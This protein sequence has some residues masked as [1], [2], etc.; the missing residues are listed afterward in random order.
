M[1][2]KIGTRQSKLALIQTEMVVLKIKSKIPDAVCEIVPIVTTGD[3]ITNKNLYDIG[4]KA[5][6][7]KEI[8]ESL[9]AGNIDLAVHSLKDVPGII[10]ENLEIAAV[11][12]REDPRDCFVSFKY[13]SIDSIPLNGVIG[14]SS[15]RRKVI[16]RQKRPDLKLVQFR[17][18]INTRMQKLRDAEVDG[19]ILACAGLKRG[20]LFDP[21]C[22][23]P[24]EF[25]EMLPAAGQ[26]IIGLEIRS[27][28]AKMREVCA[29]VNHEPTWQLAQAE[30]SFMTYLD[31]SCQ[32]PMSAYAVYEGKEIRVRYMLSDIDGQDVRYTEK[33]VSLDKASQ[34][35][36][37]AAKELR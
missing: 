17:G 11:I 3:K 29:L 20:G 1:H 35:G 5:L 28:D 4:G 8:E 14:S 31:A 19:T 23:Y 22:C 16:I 33:L 21:S 26:G 25:V 13:K 18:N 32:T 6:F 27:N 2:I 37:D 24:L 30:R 34:V 9:I 15:V 12:E 36:I 7:L 10:P